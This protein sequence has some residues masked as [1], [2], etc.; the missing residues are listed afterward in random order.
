VTLSVGDF[1]RVTYNANASCVPH[2]HLEEIREEVHEVAIADLGVF[3][4]LGIRGGAV[5]VGLRADAEPFAARPHDR[6][7]VTGTMYA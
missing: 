5:N 3:R 1:V 6:T 4:G 2:I 7:S